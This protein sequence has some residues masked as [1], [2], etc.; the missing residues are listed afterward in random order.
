M[1]FYENKYTLNCD[2]RIL[3]SY[4]LL[5]TFINALEPYYPLP[6]C[7]VCFFLSLL[8]CFSNGVDF[9]IFSVFNEATG[10]GFVC[11]VVISSCLVTNGVDLGFFFVS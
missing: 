10:L 2:H 6:P 4:K 1:G 11:F 7:F 5:S 8:F 9:G 3:Q